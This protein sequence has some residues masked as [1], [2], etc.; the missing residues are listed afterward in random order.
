[1]NA[2]FREIRRLIYSLSRQFGQPAVLIRVLSETPDYT[3]GRQSSSNLQI[4]VKRV[5]A[6]PSKVARAWAHSRPDTSRHQDFAIGGTWDS[7]TR[8]FLINKRDLPPTYSPSIKDFLY[9]RLSRY[10]VVKVA[11]YE[12]DEA[13]A[14]L[15][16]QTEDLPLLTNDVISLTDMLTL[17]HAASTDTIISPLV[18]DENI[19][20][21]ITLTDGGGQVP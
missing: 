3:V 19:H 9:F 1:M 5:V 13:I 11:E 7:R 2:E 17:K 15:C 10:E 6:L 4:N 20:D 21:I 14:L 12:E 8:A 16:T 18:I